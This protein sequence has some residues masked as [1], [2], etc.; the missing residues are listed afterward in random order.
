[1][2]WM[3][4]SPLF[5]TFLGAKGCN[6][7]LPWGRQCSIFVSKPFRSLCFHRL[8]FDYCTV[9]R[10]S[11]NLDDCATIPAATATHTPNPSFSIRSTFPFLHVATTTS[12][13]TCRTYP[14]HADPPTSSTT[15]SNSC[16]SSIR[17]PTVHYAPGSL[18]T[19]LSISPSHTT[20]TSTFASTTASTGHWRSTTSSTLTPTTGTIG[21]HSTGPKRHYIS[22]GPYSTGPKRHH[23]SHWL[24]TI[25]ITIHCISP[26][27]L[28]AFNTRNRQARQHR[29]TSAATT[30]PTATSQ[31]SPPPPQEPTQV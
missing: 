22:Q 10:H 14:H 4:D 8:A 7:D 24:P 20:S 23:F 31:Q 12:H 9:L 3:E 1:M 18:A 26:T 2:S 30:F 13:T 5:G 25:K 27:S 19:L 21:P 11:L 16:S 15:A 29:F 28:C 6:E 17:R